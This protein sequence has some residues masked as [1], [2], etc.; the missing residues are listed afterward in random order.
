[1]AINP[2]V[3]QLVLYCADLDF[4]PADINHFINQCQ[5]LGLLAGPAGSQQSDHF[6][7]GERF[8]QYVS[9]VGCSPYLKLAPESDHDDNYSQAVI[10]LLKPDISFFSTK[11]LPLPRC[12]HCKKPLSRISEALDRWEEDKKSVTVEC[13][14][15]QKTSE[16]YE[17]DWR[18]NAAFSRFY[19]AFSHIYPK[20]AIPGDGLIDWLRQYSRREWQYCY[21]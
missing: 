11:P 3:H 10:P 13:S 9:F 17:L 18:R 5:Q 2:D 6:L 20:E 8:M 21:L 14:S 4:Y 16:L 19:L 7:L 15:C 12:L 1:M